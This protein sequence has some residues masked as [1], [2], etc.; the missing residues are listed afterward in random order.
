[1]FTKNDLSTNLINNSDQLFIDYIIDFLN[2]FYKTFKI[3]DKDEILKRINVL[4][5]VGYEKKENGYICNSDKACFG[6]G[7]YYYVAI[8]KEVTDKTLIKAY[9]YHE[10]IHCMSIHYE[11]NK[12]VNG[13]NKLF[14]NNSIFD[15]IMTEYYSQKLLMNENINMENKYI[16][17]KD[18]N[19]E[20]SSTYNGCG[21]HEYMGLANMYNSLFLDSLLL[22]KF[23]DNN[24]FINELNNI[25]Y[26]NNL[27]MDYNSFVNENDPKKRYEDITIL[28]INYLIDAYKNDSGKEEIYKDYSIV[29]FMSYAP[30]EYIN[31][32]EI[33]YRLLQGII[34]NEISKFLGSQKKIKRL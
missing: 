30:K 16:Y 14:H 13:Y 29:D 31:N 7:F 26:N 1:M 19:Y 9:L 15:E 10:L 33:P 17:Q 5:Y 34:N 23:I 6:S 25:I 22:G 24:Y 28:F 21:Y 11:N 2:N 8:N 3:L 20:L 12:E 32:H 18:D 27:S 4:D